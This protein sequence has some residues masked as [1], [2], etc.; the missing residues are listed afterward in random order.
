MATIESIKAKIQGLIEKANA[1][2]SRA[3][4]Q[5]TPAVDALIA[6]YGSG[7]GGGYIDVTE[8][9]KPWKLYFADNGEIQDGEELVKK[10]FSGIASVEFFYVDEFPVPMAISGNGKSVLYVLKTDGVVYFSNDGITP[11]RFDDPSNLPIA[12]CHGL[13]DSVDDIDANVKG[14][15]TQKGGEIKDAPYRLLEEKEA[16]LTLWVA[17]YTEGTEISMPFEDFL[18][19]TGIEGNITYTVVETLPDV[20]EMVNEDTFT[21]PCYILEST[22]IAYIS[23]DGTSATAMP[24]GE[25]M[26]GTPGADKGWIDSV[27]DI[28]IDT[29]ADDVSIYTIRPGTQLVPKG[30]Y[31]YSDGWYELEKTLETTEKPHDPRVYCTTKNGEVVDWLQQFEA[32]GGAKIPFV[33]ALPLDIDGIY[34]LNANG[35]VYYVQDGQ[36]VEFTEILSG[37]NC[38]WVDSLE[39]IDTSK[40]DCLYALRGS[41]T[42]VIYKVGENGT[43]N[44]VYIH[45]NDEWQGFTKGGGSGGGGSSSNLVEKDVNFY[46][47]D[48]TLLHSYTV[49]EIQALTELPELP[50]HDGLICQGWNWSLEDLKAE[51]GCMDVGAMYVTDDGKTRLYITIESPHRMDVPLHFYQSVANGVVIDWGDGSPTETVNGAGGKAITHTYQSIGDYIISLEVVSGELKLG[52]GTASCN[53]IGQKDSMSYKGNLYR[54]MLTK[55]ELG[56]GVLDLARYSVSG[57]G[58]LT[59]ISIPKTVETIQSYAL[60]EADSV[61]FIV[62]PSDIQFASGATTVFY[63][64]KNLIGISLPHGITS[65]PTSCFYTCPRLKRIC[66]PNSVTSCGVF[67]SVNNNQQLTEMVKL[68]SGITEIKNNMFANLYRLKTVIIP[69]TITSI[70]A[71]AFQC[72]YPLKEIKIPDGV[73]SIGAYAFNQCYSVTE[74]DIPQGVTTIEQ[75]VFSAC[76][77]VKYYN[78]TKHTAVPTLSNTD[79]FNMQADDFIIRV[80]SSLYNEWITATN[81]STYASKIVGV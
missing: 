66:F 59:S 15:Y 52:Q 29:S 79:A 40:P 77:S 20:M 10:F 47:Y 64:L 62:L 57:A 18:K 13:V 35:F 65:I 54:H 11:I 3:D 75:Q 1:A 81:W 7:G 78:F 41:K 26:F 55:I 30:V 50:E 32:Q 21:F 39:E 56:N 80:P 45:E 42:D 27:D 19:M 31:A 17:A 9:P 24:F 46:D 34:V 67:W 63:T 33:D 72:C 4:T 6:G 22:G 5:L 73:T 38:G 76:G 37:T 60:A 36:A 25:G 70:G 74:F 8:L 68:P 49:E 44:E 53:V 14:F 12:V 51:N 69:N 61:K 48:G 23:F 2:T 43:T 58:Y 71:K 28:V 16:S